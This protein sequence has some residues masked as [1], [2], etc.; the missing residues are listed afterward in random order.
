MSLFYRTY[1]QRV[2]IGGLLSVFS[3]AMPPA[4]AGDKERPA[5]PVTFAY[6]TVDD[7]EIKL[8]VYRSR[9]TGPQPIVMWIRTTSPSR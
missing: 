6:K 2:A 3:V 7:L 8:D 4:R 1:V 9:E 5:Q